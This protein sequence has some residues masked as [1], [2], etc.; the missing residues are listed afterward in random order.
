MDCLIPAGR[1]R[2]AI[3]LG[4]LSAL[5]SFGTFVP[6]Y[7]DD[8]D[9]D[10]SNRPNADAG[11]TIVSAAIF[12]IDIPNIDGAAQEFNANFYMQLQWDDPRLKAEVEGVRTFDLDEIWNPR[13]LI[14]NKQRAFK[15]LPDIVEVT[16]EGRVNY[17]QRMTGLFSQTLRLNEFP[18]DRHT[19]R[20][21]LAAAG[22]SDDELQF[23]AS[24]DGA[25]SGMATVLSLADWDIVDWRAEPRAYEPV[26]GRALAGFV[27]EFEARRLPGYYIWKVLLPLVLIVMMSWAAF[28]IDPSN[29][30]SQIGVA[31]S[32]MLTLIAYRFMLGNLV[33]KLPYMTRLDYFI[34]AS[35]VIVF[36]TLVQVV[37]T[38]TLARNDRHALARNID[39]RARFV[40]PLCFVVIFCWALWL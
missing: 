16:P 29:A 3:I 1:L 30:G 4:A 21:Q 23:V 8:E 27:F 31:T 11:P 22:Y 13:L 6:I 35:T 33:P 24:A 26:P 39:R 17:R 14:T 38:A 20:I 18:F 7:G 36:F 28:W 12:V 34:L 9:L 5:F 40:F 19:F 37:L 25:E 2:R 32:S 10:S 15:S